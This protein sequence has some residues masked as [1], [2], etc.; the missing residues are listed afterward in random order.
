M[1]EFVVKL[2]S[3]KCAEILLG[4]LLQVGGLSLEWIL[5]CGGELLSERDHCIL[6]VNMNCHDNPLP[7]SSQ[8][9]K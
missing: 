6:E 3:I 2:F 1:C 4:W 9:L 8:N 7:L 5:E